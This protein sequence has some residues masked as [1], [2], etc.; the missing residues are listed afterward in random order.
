M[1]TLETL[2]QNFRQCRD[3]PDQFLHLTVFI[4]LYPYSK[5]WVTL[6]LYGPRCYNLILQP[7]IHRYI[8][9]PF[10]FHYFIPQVINKK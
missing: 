3:L 4:T 5:P 6:S 2:V 7:T 1:E 9:L 10:S 8:R